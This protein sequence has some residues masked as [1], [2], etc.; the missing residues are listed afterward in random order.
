[1]RRIVVQVVCIVCVLAVFVPAMFAVLFHDELGL[2]GSIGG[3]VT[4]G[5]IGVLL[6]EGALNVAK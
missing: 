5:M 2:L 4:L 6:L 1:M 3:F